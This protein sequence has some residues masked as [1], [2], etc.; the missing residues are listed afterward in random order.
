[1]F[2]DGRHQLRRTWFVFEFVCSDASNC[3]Q[4]HDPPHSMAIKIKCF[5]L[6]IALG[7]SFLLRALQYAY[8]TNDVNCIYLS[9]IT[10]KFNAL[11]STLYARF[12]SFAYV[13]VL[14]L[15]SSKQFIT[16]K[17]VFIYN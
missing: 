7:V 16:A 6:F 9:A 15:T 8:F 1:M 14:F 17:I 4:Q 3:L 10:I 5:S 13:F 12:V 2:N 11:N